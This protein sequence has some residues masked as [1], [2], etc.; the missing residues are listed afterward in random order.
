MIVSNLLEQGRDKVLQGRAALRTSGDDRLHVPHP[1][2]PLCRLPLPISVR[3]SLNRLSL[4]LSLSIRFPPDPHL[5]APK[6][7]AYRKAG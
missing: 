6:K 4:L 3:L 5:G 1:H 2:P 7:S